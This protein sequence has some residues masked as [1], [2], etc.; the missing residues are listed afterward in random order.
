M[1]D[2]NTYNI[3]GG[4]VGPINVGSNKY[5][6]KNL[7]DVEVE[8]YRALASREQSILE[9]R[10]MAIAQSADGPVNWLQRITSQPEAQRSTLNGLIEN[11]SYI[12]GMQIDSTGMT[13]FWMDKSYIDSRGVHFTDWYYVYGT[14]KDASVL[15]FQS[16][17]QNIH[18]LHNGK[19]VPLSDFERQ[20]F[21]DSTVIYAQAVLSMY[22]PHNS[23]SQFKLAA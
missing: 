12:G 13:R 17:A 15:R 20:S 22:R 21:L 6:P 14:G 4:E 5:T 11:E 23:N 3:P 18:K 9:A 8:P 1:I 16:T 10:V 7:S 2:K 19:E